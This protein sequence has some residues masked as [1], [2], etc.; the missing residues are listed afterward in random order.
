MTS[1]EIS[2]KLV[3]TTIGATLTVPDEPGKSA[4]RRFHRRNGAVRP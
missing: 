3:E 4:R 2:W 1:E